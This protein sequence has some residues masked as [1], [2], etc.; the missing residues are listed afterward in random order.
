MWALWIML[1]E[2]FRKLV[3]WALTRKD[4]RHER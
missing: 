2:W 4:R 3:H 1:P